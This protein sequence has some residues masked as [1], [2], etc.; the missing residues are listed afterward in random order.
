MALEQAGDVIFGGVVH[1][2][3]GAVSAR[4]CL[5]RT[6]AGQQ[7]RPVMIDVGTTGMGAGM[8]G[9]HDARVRH[10]HPEAVDDLA[11]DFP[12]L[13]II[14]AHPGWPRVEQTTAVALHKSNV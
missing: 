14:M 5:Q 9:R 3:D 7:M 8:P 2:G 6:D 12:Q 4:Q 11:A 10:A 1:G 13:K